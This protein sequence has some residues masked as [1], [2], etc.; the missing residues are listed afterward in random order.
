MV[1]FFE[2]SYQQWSNATGGSWAEWRA[3]G[4]G[5]WAKIK[6][7]GHYHGG[8]TCQEAMCERA[9]KDVAG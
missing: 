9:V 8:R 2:Q 6:T 7:S 3:L 1:P 4:A 5:L